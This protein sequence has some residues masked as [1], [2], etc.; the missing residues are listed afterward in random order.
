[1]HSKI[2]ELL[3]LAVANQA[4]DLHLAVG[5]PPR[6]R[7]NGEL[8]EVTNWAVASDDE[9]NGMIL[10]ILDEKQKER[11][12]ADREMD[13][14]LAMAE[15]RFRVNIYF[16]KGRTAAAFR[17]VPVEIP[18]LDTLGLPEVIR[19]FIKLKQG[20]ILMTGPTG[21]GKSTTLASLLNEINKSQ[22]KH[23]VTVEDP[24]EYVI[25]PLKSIISQRELGYDTNSFALALRS[26]LRQDPNVVLVGE[27]RD[28]ETI[29]S[30]LTIAETGHLVFSTLHTNSATQTIDRVI[31]VFPEGSK[32]QIRIQLAE[33]ITAVLSQRLVPTLDGKRRPA[34]EVLIATPAVKN[35]IREG[36]TFMID[37]I[38]QTSVDVGM[39]NME[40]SL[41]AMVRA[42]MISEE[43]ALSYCLRPGELQDRLRK[44]RPENAQI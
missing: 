44:T 15:A 30:A 19:S 20:F 9:Y 4:S 21:H 22:A 42:G 41:A 27:M 43:V 17:V 11:F 29:S 23:I 31:D 12:L 40:T 39:M 13:F 14:S 10:S 32:E 25:S 1:M 38:I 28:L 16:Q 35:C 18:Q 5:M 24:V 33:V 3:K 26:A 2:E 34:V 6:L 37:N 7:V 36:K 8:V